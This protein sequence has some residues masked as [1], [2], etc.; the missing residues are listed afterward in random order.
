MK[1]K[2]LFGKKNKTNTKPFCFIIPYQT[3]ALIF[4]CLNFTEPATSF[5]F[6]RAFQH[7]KMKLLITFIAGLPEQL[8]KMS[9]NHR[10]K[11]LLHLILHLSA[12]FHIKHLPVYKPSYS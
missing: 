12:Y 5:L 6:S 1:L 4:F 9:R 3:L 7:L 8:E 2:K 11:V 10:G